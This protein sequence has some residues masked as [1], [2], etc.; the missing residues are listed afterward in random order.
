MKTSII[1]FTYAGGTSSFFNEIE[2]DLPDYSFIKLEY[3]GHGTRHKE[4]FYIDFDE[5]ADDLYSKIKA[6]YH[7]EPYA[8]FGYSMGTI[9]LVEVLKRIQVKSEIPLPKHAFLAAHEPHTKMELQGFDDLEGDEWVKERTIRFGAVPEKLIDNET[10]WRMYLPLYRADYS[11]IGKY[12]F[13]D[14]SLETEV[15]ATIFY[16]EGDTPFEEMKLWKKYFKGNCDFKCF[17]GR[18]FFIQDNHA[19]MAEEIKRALDDEL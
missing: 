19:E 14:L 2:K 12:I 11:L 16:A 3:A 10:F 9:A 5:L 1:C 17:N 13:K 4:K 8:L 18:H 7:G 15:P 6:N